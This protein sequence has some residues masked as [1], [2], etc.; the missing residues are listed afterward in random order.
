MEENVEILERELREIERAQRENERQ[1]VNDLVRIQQIRN[2]L[3]I[4]RQQWPTRIIASFHTLLVNA[5]T[6]TK[7]LAYYCFIIGLKMLRY[8]YND[9][10]PKVI[11]FY[12]NSL[13][14][15]SRFNKD[16]LIRLFYSFIGLLVTN[17]V[18]V[19]FGSFVLVLLSTTAYIIVIREYLDRTN[20]NFCALHKEAAEVLYFDALGGLRNGNQV[21]LR[22][23]SYTPQQAVI[24]SSFYGDPRAMNFLGCLLYNG[25]KLHLNKREARKWFEKSAELGNESASRNLHLW[26]S[27]ALIAV[28][29]K[30]EY[31]D[32]G[33]K[34][35]GSMQYEL[36]VKW[37]HESGKLGNRIAFRYL[38]IIEENGYASNGVA[39]REL[40]AQYYVLSAEA[41]DEESKRILIERLLNASRQMMSNNGITTFPRRTIE[42]GG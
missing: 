42:N 1:R 31:F 21:N 34:Y 36:S 40:A 14:L 11:D 8:I 5:T 25:E 13:Y 17:L 15:M 23:V 20:I 12:E 41:G 35:Y 33:A 26:Q 38:G 27:N 32:V 24:E 4:R 3:D 16:Q 29:I 9:A 28:D 37:L 2:R 19:R 22:G 30:Q 6:A 7:Q 39:N 10:F 18:M